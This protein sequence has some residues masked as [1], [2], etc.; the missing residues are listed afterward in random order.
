[1]SEYV[2][3][4]LYSRKEGVIDCDLCWSPGLA[5]WLKGSNPGWSA[6]VAA[7]PT[8]PKGALVALISVFNTKKKK[9]KKEEKENRNALTVKSHLGWRA[10]VCSA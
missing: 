6:G 10:R 5:T 2:Y 4:F 7:P 9:K 3:S 8:G 1:M